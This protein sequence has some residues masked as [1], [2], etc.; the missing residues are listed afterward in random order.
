VCLGLSAS[1]RRRPENRFT[2]NM[3]YQ[4]SPFFGQPPHGVL[5][6]EKIE[7]LHVQ[8]DSGNPICGHWTVSSHVQS[9]RSECNRPTLSNVINM[10]HAIWRCLHRNAERVEQLQEIGRGQVDGA[11]ICANDADVLSRFF[12]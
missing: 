2:S 4:I 11:V 1:T 6:S 7:H 8:K 10:H 9:W 12:A 5:V 3:P